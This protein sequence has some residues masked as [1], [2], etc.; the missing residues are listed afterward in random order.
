MVVHAFNP[1]RG[2]RDRRI[3]ELRAALSTEEV[4]GNAGIHRQTLSCREGGS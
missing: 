2:G 3:S 1:N 4:S